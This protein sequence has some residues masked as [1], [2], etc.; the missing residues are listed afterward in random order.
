MTV[1]SY[2]NNLASNLIIR[3]SEKQSIKKSNDTLETRLNNYFGNEIGF[4]SV[5]GSY[6]RNT[7]LPRIYDENSDID[8]M[9]R[10]TDTSYKPQTYLNKLRRF[11]EHWYSTSEIH[12]S[13]PTIVLELNHIKFELVP[14]IF[15]GS[16]VLGTY[17]IPSKAS[18]YEDWIYS[19]PFDFS[20]TVTEKNKAHNSQIKPLIRI[21]KRWNRINGGI[22][23]SFELE[24]MI[25]NH[26]FY[27]CLFD[28]NANLR[29]Y[30]YDF[31]SSLNTWSLSYQYQKNAVN[32]LKSKVEEAKNDEIY[33]PS[34]AE[35]TIKSIFE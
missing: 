8:V 7:I 4:V 19:S 10:F 31:A 12:Q 29:S 28:T 20:K 14:S 2:L 23:E 32:K 18:S 17:K 27:T 5:F 11:A 34:S 9:V 3:D 22:Y 6:Q 15:S 35:D 26:G 13:N 16:S 30:F 1:N 21:M 33:Y 24:Q 25:V